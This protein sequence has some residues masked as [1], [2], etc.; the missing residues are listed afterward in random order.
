VPFAC[1]RLVFFLYLKHNLGRC[2]CGDTF[3]YF[4]RHI[5]YYF[6]EFWHGQNPNSPLSPWIYL[7]RDGSLAIVGF[8]Y[9][10]C[11]IN[12]KNRKAFPNN[13]SNNNNCH[14]LLFY[15]LTFQIETD[16]IIIYVIKIFS[17]L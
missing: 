10:V 2:T 17:M 13:N 3:C 5:F 16:E 15:R 8:D 11:F 9:F 4:W 14:E 6:I 7:V 12:R 1:S